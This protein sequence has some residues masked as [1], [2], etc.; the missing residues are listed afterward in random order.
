MGTAMCKGMGLGSNI[1]PDEASMCSLAL[2]ATL[3][4]T[5]TLMWMLV[6]ALGLD[7]GISMEPWTLCTVMFSETDIDIG[8]CMD[9]A[10]ALVLTLT[11]G[12]TVDLDVDVDVDIGVDVCVA[13]TLMCVIEIVVT[14]T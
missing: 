6:S 11:F 4:L 13:L 7:L 9:T 1:D 12:M 2:D 10:L 14:C 5:A 8:C 3:A